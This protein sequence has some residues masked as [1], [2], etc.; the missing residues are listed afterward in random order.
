MPATKTKP[1]VARRATQSAKAKTENDARVID[2]VSQ[3]LDAAQEDL[4][5]IGGSLG[6]GARDLRKDVERLLRDARRDLKKMSKALRRDLE[7]LQ[8]DLTKTAA[9][10]GRTA[11]KNG[12]ASAAASTKRGAKA[13]A[14]H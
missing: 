7:H 8:K 6:A 1:T 10:N 5:S 9:S 11:V 2:H 12:N 13:Q 4:A 14:S 3:A